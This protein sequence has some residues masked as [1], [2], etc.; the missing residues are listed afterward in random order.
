ME[1]QKILRLRGQGMQSMYALRDIMKNTLFSTA[2]VRF[3]GVE[4]V[5]IWGWQISA[6]QMSHIHLR[7]FPFSGRSLSAVFI[8][9][10]K[11][12]RSL[13]II[14][15]TQLKV[16]STGFNLEIANSREI[17]DAAHGELDRHTDFN[18]CHQPG[19][20]SSHQMSFLRSLIFELDHQQDS[21]SSRL[22]TVYSPSPRLKIS[23]SKMISSSQFY[24]V[25]SRLYNLLML[26]VLSG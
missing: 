7:I 3:L 9:V 6:W 22:H 18:S 23:T 8:F 25:V 2:N 19:L 20:L 4:N 14:R 10:K 21:I 5:R 24:L 13:H 11:D 15:N 16:S 12:C 26:R 1:F 17:V